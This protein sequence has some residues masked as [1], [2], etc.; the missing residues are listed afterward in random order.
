MQQRETPWYSRRP[1]RSIATTRSVS[2]SRFSAVTSKLIAS[3]GM[4][5]GFALGPVFLPTKQQNTHPALPDGVDGKA[6]M[7]SSPLALAAIGTF[8]EYRLVVNG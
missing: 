1:R 3:N 6:D 7:P 8:S 5:T 2:G 4:R